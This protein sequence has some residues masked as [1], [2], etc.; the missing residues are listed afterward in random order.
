MQLFKRIF[1]LSSLFPIY[2]IVKAFISLKLL[3]SF[4]LKKTLKIHVSG[5]HNSP[6]GGSGGSGGS[7]GHQPL[8]REEIVHMLRIHGASEEIVTCV[9]KKV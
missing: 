1:F 7:G 4:Y 3:H 6:P 5:C 2:S 9:V 8:S